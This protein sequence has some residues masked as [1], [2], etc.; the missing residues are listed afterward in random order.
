MVAH[1]LC[2]LSI[3]RATRI[4]SPFLRGAVCSR[5]GSSRSFSSPQSRNAPI[6]PVA[7]TVSTASSPSMI[8]GSLVVAISLSEESLYRNTSIGSPPSTPS[9]TCFFGSNTFS[10]LFPRYTPNSTSFTTISVFFVP[11]PSSN[12]MLSSFLSPC[13]YFSSTTA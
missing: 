9:G 2:D 12:V 1:S 6:P 8:F 10:W 5:K 11:N 4:W 13:P 3:Y 7:A